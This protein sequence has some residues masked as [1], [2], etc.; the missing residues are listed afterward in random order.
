MALPTCAEANGQEDESV[1]E[2]LKEVFSLQALQGTQ[3]LALG[4]ML[5]GCI[6]Q[7]KTL[8][9]IP[10]T[11][12]N[13]FIQPGFKTATQLLEAGPTFELGLDNSEHSGVLATNL[14]CSRHPESTSGIFKIY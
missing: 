8:C 7:G 2:A 11:L 6:L 1:K 12:F 10:F 4:S 3:A 5:L 13:T 9:S 14:D